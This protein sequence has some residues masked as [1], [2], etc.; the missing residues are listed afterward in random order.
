LQARSGIYRM[1]VSEQTGTLQSTINLGG[2][3]VVLKL[4][5]EG[6]SVTGVFVADPC[7]TSASGVDC[8]GG[9]RLKVLETLTAV[10]NN[11]LESDEFHYWGILGDNFYDNDGTIS[12]CFFDRFSLQA[13]A[14]PFI[15]VPGNHDFW[16]YGQ[17]GQAS[18]ND[19]LA[20]GFAQ[21]YGQDTAAATKDWAFNF[22]GV[23]YDSKNLPAADNFIIGM[24]LGDMAFFGFS[25]A[26]GWQATEPHAR[27]FCEH[28]GASETVNVINVLGHWDEPN[29]GCQ[30][31]MHVRKVTEKM[32][33]MPGCSQKRVLYFEGHQH[34]NK[35]ME[36]ETGP[37]DST[38]FM[39]GGAG[40]TGTGCSLLAVPLLDILGFPGLFQAG[41]SELGLAVVTSFPDR[42]DGAQVR[43]DYISLAEDASFGTDPGAL[44]D[45]SADLI[46]CFEAKGYEACREQFSIGFRALPGDTAALHSGR[47]HAATAAARCRKG[48][49]LDIILV[50]IVV[51]VLLLALYSL[52]RLS[53]RKW[54]RCYTVR[55]PSVGEISLQPTR[56][57]FEASQLSETLTPQN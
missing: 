33:A 8:S 24:Q 17:P 11:A 20:V 40:M 27:A 18:S 31:D 3:E 23:S 41:C 53:K 16:L 9:E 48:Q 21:F 6:G 4:P 7:Y 36:Q 56:P 14:K 28:M 22:S 49:I 25:G 47:K 15:S 34:C 13:R 37:E 29:M 19:Q 2:E 26:H 43:V 1:S 51:L 10:L 30:G 32:R 45:N 5:A 57:S 39:V 42:E 35:V 12:R 38:G 46:A 44:K 50:C 52:W 54:I 55:R